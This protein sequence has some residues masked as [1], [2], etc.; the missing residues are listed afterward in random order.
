MVFL[1]GFWLLRRRL[2]TRRRELQ[3]EIAESDARTEE[4]AHNRILLDEAELATLLREGIHAGRSK[5][6]LDD[7]R[8]AFDRKDFH[9]ALQIA[10]SVHDQ[11]V[12]LRQTGGG[13][14]SGPTE[15]PTRDPFDAGRSA[16]SDPVGD[17]TATSSSEP[18][19]RTALPRNQVE[20]RFQIRLLTEELVLAVRS[21]PGPRARR[22]EPPRARSERAR[23]SEGVHRGPTRR[24][25]GPSGPRRE[26]RSA[27]ALP[28]VGGRRGCHSGA[29]GIEL[30]REGG[31]PLDALVEWA[32]GRGVPAVPPAGPCG[33]RV[34]PLLR[35]PGH[36][37][38]VPE[39]RGRDRGRRSVLPAL[40]RSD[41]L[42]R[43]EARPLAGNQE[44]FETPL[45][46][47]LVEDR[48]LPQP[49]IQGDREGPTDPGQDRR[50]VREPLRSGR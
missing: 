32:D 11:L 7:A 42:N 41:R 23:G 1:A 33:R 26:G 40:R 17:D 30:P 24:P 14:P 37:P 13:S 22:S 28:N 15:R 49:P 6:L 10:R 25:E 20:S 43:R 50:E 48:A 39:V 9:H 19:P 4:R 27:S 46:S 18:R 3:G 5:L 34:L 21:R 44:L 2:A 16:G 29:D 8:A 47:R 31:G 12:R 38:Q 35:R 36:G 45:G